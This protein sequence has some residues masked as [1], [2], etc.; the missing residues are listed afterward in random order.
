M[1]FDKT[2][3]PRTGIMSKGPKPE[4]GDYARVCRDVQKQTSPLGECCGC[5]EDLFEMPLEKRKR[6][7]P[8]DVEFA[9]KEIRIDAEIKCCPRS[10]KINRG[11]FPETMSGPLQ[12]GAGI[13]AFA[14]DLMISQMAPLKL[15]A[16]IDIFF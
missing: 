10:N 3:K 14:T 5:G 4:R 13:V 16:Q 6:R 7:V 9:T 8:V 11:T 15:T 12:Y 2:A 1:P